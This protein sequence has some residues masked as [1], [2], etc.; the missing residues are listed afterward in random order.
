[1][2]SEGRDQVS[3]SEWRRK[4]DDGWKGDGSGCEV[5]MRKSLRVVVEEGT[6]RKSERARSTDEQ[7]KRRGA[8]TL[9]S[10]CW[11]AKNPSATIC[12]VHPIAP[13]ACI[14]RNE[15]RIWSAD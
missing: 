9:E 7:E 14:S 3:G 6:E 12:S 2:R 11:L 5:R 10:V 8:H 1:M 4:G 13:S 15:L